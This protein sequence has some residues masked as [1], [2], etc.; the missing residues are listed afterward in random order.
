MVF[1]KSQV[2]Y[3]ETAA[4]LS[5]C[6]SEPV[7]LTDETMHWRK[8]KALRIMAEHGYDAIAVY[9]DREH[10]D[11]FAYLTG[12]QPRFEEAVLVLHA[13][14]NAFLLLGNEMMPMHVHARIRAQAV[15][16]PYF[17][18]PN[19]PM[20]HECPLEEVFRKAGIQSGSRIGLIG[21]K[22]FTG[23]SRDSRLL[24]DVPSFITDA[25]KQAAG[26][27]G[28][29]RNASDIMISPEYGIR[30]RMNANETAH[31]EYG[32][33]L[34]SYGMM[35]MMDAAEAGR[36]EMELA[37]YLERF[38]APNTV[39]TICAFGERYTDAVVQPR[40]NRLCC[41]DRFAA[42]VGY[43]GGLTSRKGY[44]VSDEKELPETAGD[45]LER[46]AK[47]Y[48]AAA[49]SWYAT[50]GLGITGGAVYDCIEEAIPK[51]SY[52]WTL[53]PG[54]L[55]GSEEWMSSP[56]YKDSAVQLKSGMM[57]QM[58][59]IPNVEGYGGVNAED[60]IV[61]ADGKLQ[62]QL[63]EEYPQVFARMS[64]RREYMQKEL[65]IPLKEEVLPL[66]DTSGYLRPFLLN[67]KKAFQI[68]K[69]EEG[70]L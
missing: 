34:A 28:E 29:V 24:F 27:D 10:G 47:P 51:E 58:D 20:D 33:A 25:V 39:Q 12:F 65:G 13:D 46:V 60:G 55:I 56:F 6:P 31:Y 48:Y 18:L 66:S 30:T 5:E 53:N 61:L 64:R 37:S 35:Q 38:G 41:G 14:G 26:K 17:S 22:M 23:V 4:P 1:H 52:G 63:Q 36:S 49:A 15:H 9:A 11:N 40:A 44:A 70:A 7:V 69:I 67:R 62:N 16:V 45:Y 68:R 57:L 43:S 54:H 3:Q 21:W 32:A 8:E 42:T 2:I 19:Q 59:I 50:V